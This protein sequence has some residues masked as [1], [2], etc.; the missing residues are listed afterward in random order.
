V[1]EQRLDKPTHRDR[2]LV[3]GPRR[4]RRRTRKTLGP[5]TRRGAWIASP[6]WAMSSWSAAIAGEDLVRARKGPKCLHGCR[7]TRSSSLVER[8]VAHGAIALRL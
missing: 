7:T 2:V 4:L 8:R 5:S 1:V 6:D 3:L